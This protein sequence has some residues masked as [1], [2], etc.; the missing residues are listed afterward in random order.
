MPGTAEHQGERW[1]LLQSLPFRVVAFLSLALLPIGL[2]AIWQTESL[3]ETLR[4][5]TSLSLVALSELAISGERDVVQQAIGVADGLAVNYQMTASDPETCSAYFRA[6]R[7]A[8]PNITFTGFLQA[9]GRI[10]CSSALAPLTLGPADRIADITQNPMPSFVPQIAADGAVTDPD[11]IILTRPLT[12]GDTVLGQI[13]VALSTERLVGTADLNSTSPPLSLLVFNTDGQIISQQGEV[14]ATDQTALVN[15]ATQQRDGEPVTVMGRNGDGAR[16]VNVIMTLVPGLAYAMTSWAPRE[17]FLASNAI[18]LPSFFLPALMWFASLLVAYFAVHRL[19]VG[20]V[21]ELRERMQRFASDR[22]LPQ[23][24]TSE[25]LPQELYDLE[26]TFVDMA[27]D[28]IDDEAR[29]ENSLREKNVLLKE[30]HHRVKNNLQMISSIMNMQIRTAS[31]DESRRALRRLQDRVLGLATVHRFIYQSK[32]LSRVDAAPLMADICAGVFGL[33]QDLH[34][35]AGHKLDVDHFSLVPDQ[36]VPLSL[37]IGEVSTNAV[38]AM[39]RARHPAPFPHISLRIVA[40]GTALL[41]CRSGA[42][43]DPANPKSRAGVGT[44]LIRAFAMQLGGTLETL[45]QDGAHTVSLKFPITEGVPD[46]L[47]Y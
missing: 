46:A 35:G 22:A 19:V 10:F 5:R 28:L 20:P 36:A 40:P 4:A 7:N 11:S 23:S 33:L 45:D 42:I 30:V 31:S 21:Q 12:E 44:Q 3:D 8:D 29:M 16:R 38:Q 27:Y 9:D 32:D 26:Q 15:A 39:S 6:Y 25:L 18:A 13:I 37:L 1:P 47:D 2:L 43:H 14:I 17:G 34:P 24:R 41:R